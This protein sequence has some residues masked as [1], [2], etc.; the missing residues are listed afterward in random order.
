M[1]GVGFRKAHTYL[2]FR[3]RPN[4]A[5]GR[6]ALHAMAGA[7]LNRPDPDPAPAQAGRGARLGG[8][9]CRPLRG[10]PGTGRVTNLKSAAERTRATAPKPRGSGAGLPRNP[11]SD[12]MRGRHA[13]AAAFCGGVR[14]CIC[15]NVHAR[16]PGGRPAARAPAWFDEVAAEHC[17]SECRRAL[18][19]PRRTEAVRMRMSRMPL[20][21]DP[22]AARH[23]FSKAALHCAGP[24]ATNGR[25]ILSAAS[26]A[27]RNTAFA[28]APS[29][30]FVL[31]FC[32]WAFQALRSLRPRRGR[33]RTVWAAGAQPRLCAHAR[34]AYTRAGPSRANGARHCPSLALL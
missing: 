20:N 15:A 25:G 4:N 22:A 5:K 6:E 12:C 31:F 7:G 10:R 34:D 18:F 14:H 27:A 16:G 3:P 11:I 9:I 21:P 33:T 23:A 2:A 19:M 17:N 13:A 26:R 30:A 32:T 28:A 8:A 29:V 24:P 1:R